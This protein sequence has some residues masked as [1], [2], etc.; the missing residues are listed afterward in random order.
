MVTEK[1][2]DLGLA[3]IGLA[4]EGVAPLWRPERLRIVMEARNDEDR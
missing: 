1:T 4:K 2:V 3:I